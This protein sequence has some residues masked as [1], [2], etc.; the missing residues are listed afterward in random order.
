MHDRRNSE[1]HRRLRGAHGRRRNGLLI[2][3]SISAFRLLRARATA[4]R[5]G[6]V[7]RRPNDGLRRRP[8]RWWTAGHLK[9]AIRRGPLPPRARTAGCEFTHAPESD[10]LAGAR[11]RRRPR[12]LSRQPR[13]RVRGFCPNKSARLEAPSNRR[14]ARIFLSVLRSATDAQVHAAM[15]FV[16]A[17]QH[18]TQAEIAAMFPPI[19]TD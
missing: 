4:S 9:R 8:P 10:A 17:S 6:A 7:R 18:V 15:P 12:F 3:T 11:A 13:V 14:D 2:Y 5:E 19:I 1:R 16:Q